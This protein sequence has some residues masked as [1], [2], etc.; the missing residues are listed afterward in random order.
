MPVAQNKK[1][2]K[3]ARPKQVPIV[4]RS[5]VIGQKP[6]EMHEKRDYSGSD[7]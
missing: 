3:R 7:E 1:Q 6:K 5:G 2:I 4:L